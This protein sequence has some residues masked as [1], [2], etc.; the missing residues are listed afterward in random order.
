MTTSNYYDN[1]NPNEDSMEYGFL[2]SGNDQ[3]INMI[4]SRVY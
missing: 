1:P 2:S 3:I 4:G